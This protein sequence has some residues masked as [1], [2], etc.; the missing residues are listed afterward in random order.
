[1]PI[2]DY[3][4]EKCEHDFTLIEPI[5]EHGRTKPKCPECKS[6]RVTRVFSPV[7]VRTAKKS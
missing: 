3:R 4:C 2:Y 1:M 6:T 5:S 7:T